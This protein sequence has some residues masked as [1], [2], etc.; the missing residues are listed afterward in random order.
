MQDHID[1]AGR[2]FRLDLV[3]ALTAPQDRLDRL[4]AEVTA[5]FLT[6]ES[7]FGVNP[8]VR[9]V[10]PA[11]GPADAFL[12][13]PAGLISQLAAEDAGRIDR[14]V[15]LTTWGAQVH[16]ALV[17]AGFVGRRID[18]PAG[19][20]DTWAFLRGDATAGG[21]T[22]YVE[23]V[24]EADEKDPAGFRPAYPGRDGRDGRRCLRGDP[25]P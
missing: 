9:I 24:N 11:T 16:D 12:T 10:Y 18:M 23:A 1:I 6:R 25:C 15:V 14:T 17:G 5:L 22:L 2:T 4:G 20:H 3:S 8:D 21:R 13:D 7:E 19:P